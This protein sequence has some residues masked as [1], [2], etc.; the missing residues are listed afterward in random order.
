VLPTIAQYVQRGCQYSNDRWR[1][2]TAPWHFGR[3]GTSEIMFPP[4]FVTGGTLVSR[5]SR[6]AARD[7]NRSTVR[8]S[9]MKS[10]DDEGARDRDER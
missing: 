7:G 10:E 6:L 2:A 8:R 5:S 4:G 1:L 9:R 3:I